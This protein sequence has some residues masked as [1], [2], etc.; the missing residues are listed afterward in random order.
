MLFEIKDIDK[1][2]YEDQIRDFIPEKIIDIHTHVYLK[3]HKDCNMIK[4]LPNNWFDRVAKDQSIEDLL[5]SY[6]LLFPG[7]QITPLVFF[8]AVNL[9][10][11][12]GNEFVGKVAEKHN[13]PALIFSKPT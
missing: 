13:F 12:E 4:R 8:A 10:L 7:K 5:E 11:A 2:T 6:E 3:E 1:K 9:D